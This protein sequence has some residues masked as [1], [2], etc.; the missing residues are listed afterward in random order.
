VSAGLAW[1]V[2]LGA[3]VLTWH[4]ADLADLPLSRRYWEDMTVAA[5]RLDP[6]PGPVQE[7]GSDEGLERRRALQNWVVRESAEA[8]LRPWQPWRGLPLRPYLRREELRNRPTEDEGRARLLGALFRLRGQVLPYAGL[9]LGALAALPVFLAV[10]MELAAAGRAAAGSLLVLLC[11]LSPFFV[12]SLSLPY[13]G[14]GFFVLALLALCGLAAWATGPA[15]SLQGLL[16]RAVGYTLFLALAVALRGSATALAP[17]YALA[18]GL[19][20]FRTPSRLRAAAAAVAILAL[21]LLAMRGDSRHDTWVTL[22]EGLGDF[23]RRYGHTWSDDAV[24]AIAVREGVDLPP[25]SPIFERGAEIDA[26]MK[27]HVVAAIRHDPAWYLG[28]LGKRALATVSLYKLWPWA[29]WGGASM[30]AAT[31]LNEGVMDDYWSMT[32]PA[33]FAGL[34]PWRAELPV[35]LLVAPTLGLLALV[36]GRRLAP[37]AAVLLAV[38]GVAGLGVPVA[39]T[40]CSGLETEAFVLVHL[41]SAS[42]LADHAWRRHERP[43]TGPG[44]Q[45]TTNG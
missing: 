30:R 1:I 13:S 19:A 24:R 20:G 35:P 42:L 18:L 34:G 41:L 16:A 14:I 29:P 6:S 9:W 39:V 2:L 33:D 10:A 21:G 36:A 4:T 45:G 32:T 22:W 25:R 5:S 37:A 43:A 12:E 44:V 31:T 17:G 3:T 8:G 23:D 11:A 7:I 26:V 28:I 40:T 38:V 27:P 15:V